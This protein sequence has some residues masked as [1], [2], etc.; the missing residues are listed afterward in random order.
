MKLKMLIASALMSVG[1]IGSAWAEPAIIYDLGGKFDKSFNR[2][3]FNGTEKWK[4]R[5]GAIIESLNYNQML[6]ESKLFGI[7]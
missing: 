5:A 1:L 3:A 6:S 7:R 4:K 2:S